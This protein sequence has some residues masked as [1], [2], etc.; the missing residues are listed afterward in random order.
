[1]GGRWSGGGNGDGREGGREGS[2]WGEVR[3]VREVGEGDG[4][5]CGG[6]RRV[7]GPEERRIAM[8]DD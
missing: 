1:M 7:E 4:H 5:V 3:V 8:S 6:I 2:S